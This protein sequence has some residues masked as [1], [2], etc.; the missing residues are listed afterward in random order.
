MSGLDSAPAAHGMSAPDE[1]PP[2][3]PDLSSGQQDK[4]TELERL[5]RDWNGRINLVS[6]KD[7]DAFRTHHLLHSIVLAKWIQFAPRE[8][9][10]DVGTG[11]GLPGLPLAIL[12]PETTFHLCDS[13]AKKARAVEAMA[14]E[15][16]LPN[17]AVINKRAEKL[18]S[19]W[20]YVLGRA[21]T[22]LPRFLGWIRTN[23]R[24]GGKGDFGYGVFYWKGD[25][26]AE[27][28]SAAG[29]VPDAVL[30]LSEVDEDPYF[31]GKYIIHL[32]TRTVLGADLPREEGGRPIR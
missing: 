27:E 26:Y 30:P 11:G 4:L 28:L 19:K 17:V 8:R 10:L 29:I 7:M 21:V 5:F 18:E 2:V 12:F 32:K 24:P 23:L 3:F 25:R 15:L 31:Q 20:H 9:V 16:D 1:Q 14:K 13:I 6:R 22:N